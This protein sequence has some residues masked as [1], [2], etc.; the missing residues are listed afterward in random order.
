M[1]TRVREVFSKGLSSVVEWEDGSGYTRRSVFPSTELVTENGEVFVE[2]IEEG[3]SYGVDWED[4]IH[5]QVGP[6]GIADLLR[7][8]G[9][10]TLKD[11][12]QNTRVVN[13]VFQEA[14]TLNFQHF[15]Q[16]VARQEKDE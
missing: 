15:K 9:I 7:K 11:Y 16:S 1:K 13:S 4:Y 14:C 8:H 5:T 2:N 6:K 12:A 3:Q 10:W